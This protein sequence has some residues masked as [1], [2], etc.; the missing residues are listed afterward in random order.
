MIW[1]TV[2]LF[3][4]CAFVGG[5]LFLWLATAAWRTFLLSRANIQGQLDGLERRLER[6]ETEVRY[7]DEP[8]PN[9]PTAP[10]ALISSLPTIEDW[11][12]IEKT[13]EDGAKS[14]P[15]GGPTTSM[16]VPGLLDK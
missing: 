13:R 1:N 9:P 10:A 6:V 7:Q 12:T 3:V 5:V 11:K 4:A 2:S 16:V 8:A 15:I 14:T